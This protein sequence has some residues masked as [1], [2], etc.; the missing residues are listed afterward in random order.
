MSVAA[1]TRESAATTLRLLL[2]APSSQISETVRALVADF[3]GR[4]AWTADDAFRFL[5]TLPREPVSPPP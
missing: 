2:V 3:L 5:A 4:E 1:L